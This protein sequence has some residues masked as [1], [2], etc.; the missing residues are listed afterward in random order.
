MKYTKLKYDRKYE[1]EL[2]KK[3]KDYQEWCPPV[4][5]EKDET[6]KDDIKE[7]CRMIFVHLYDK[8][9]T[10]D[11]YKKVLN[12]SYSAR[13][14]DRFVENDEVYSNWTYTWV[15]Y[16]EFDWNDLNITICSEVGVIEK[17]FFAFMFNRDIHVSD[18][19]CRIYYKGILLR[20]HDQTLKILQKFYDDIIDKESKVEAEYINKINDLTEDVTIKKI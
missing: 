1:K 17:S 16:F 6:K 5:Y 8:Q 15:R 13:L 18:W 12:G 10:A 9:A 7:W 20:D 19:W 11:Y 2:A 3:W 14:S 4:R